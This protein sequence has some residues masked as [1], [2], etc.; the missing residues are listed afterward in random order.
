[1][2]IEKLKIEYGDLQKKLVDQGFISDLSKYREVAARVSKLEKIISA[3]EAADKLKKEILDL[4]EMQNSGDNDLAKMAGEELQVKEI[5]LKKGEGLLEK[6]FK[7]GE[8][9]EVNKI[10]MEIRAGAGGL[11]ASLFAEE[12]FNMYKHYS[13]KSGSKVNVIDANKTDLGGYKEVVFEIEGEDVYKKL[14]YESGVHRV[15]RIPETEKNGRIH[16]ST[17]SVAVLPEAKDVDIEVRPD[18]IKVEFYRSS[19]PGGQNVNKVETAVRLIHLPTGVIVNCQE[20]RSQQ[21]NREKAMTILKTRL[22]DAKRQEEE[23]KMSAERKKQIGTADRSEKIR[24]Y[25]FPQDRITD[26]RINKSWH[27]ITSILEGNMEDVVEAFG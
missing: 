24:T 27:N 14:K 2:E 23:K 18:D 26:H 19:G 3:Y 17:V 12:L 7:G 21:K 25:N 22:L 1:M 20:G 16:T 9:E 8:E 6:L 10:I 13:E 4:K 5:E 11:E 15:Q